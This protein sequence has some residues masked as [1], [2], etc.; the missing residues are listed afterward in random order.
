MKFLNSSW[1]IKKIFYFNFYLLQQKFNTKHYKAK[2]V[3]Q[4]YIFQKF[5]FI[6]TNIGGRFAG[7]ST[8]GADCAVSSNLLLPKTCLL[9]P[10]H[11]ITAEFQKIEKQNNLDVLYNNYSVPSVPNAKTISLKLSKQVKKASNINSAT[12]NNRKSSDL[13]GR[14]KPEKQHAKSSQ[15]CSTESSND[16][17]NDTYANIEDK[18]LERRYANNTRER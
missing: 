11:S 10:G 8:T 12:K 15:N 2:I 5:C 6:E 4:F 3:L 14:A 13:I 18:E 1:L 7:Y 9:L 17:Q 16:A